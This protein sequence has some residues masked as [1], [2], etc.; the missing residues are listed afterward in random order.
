MKTLIT[1]IRNS[2]ILALMVV[3]VVC[4][5][6]LVGK[7]HSVSGHAFMNHDGRTI[8]LKKGMDVHDSAQI[9][10]S[11]KALVSVGDFYDRYYHLSSGTSVILN[12][13][14]LALQSGSVWSQAVKTN[15]STTI[16]T[17]NLLAQSFNS[18][19]VVTYSVNDKKSQITVISG[20]VNVASPKQPALRY[21]LVAGQFS[22][23]HPDVD[24]GY[25]RT[26]TR[27]G[28]ES[29][30]RT[31]SLFPGVKARDEG[32]AHIQKNKKQGRAI[33]SVESK[34]L[35]HSTGEII[36]IKTNK[37][38]TRAPASSGEAQ[39]YYKNRTYVNKPL[40]K[41]GAQ[42]RVIGASSLVT[43]PQRQVA[44][45]A[46]TQEPLQVREPSKTSEFLKS[47]QFQESHQHKHTPEVQRLIDDLKSF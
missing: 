40:S 43:A 34:E 35:G 27:L 1:N 31:L 3:P 30:N 11:D 6:K 10:V 36:Y 44:S 5:A 20:D 21:A 33:A 23:A 17:A 12:E 42:V 28:F 15:S 25:P 13:R 19:F 8:T 32:I 22:S 41:L 9:I 18:E 46:K 26:P 47:Y 14:S 29:L 37:N 39:K 24:E 38:P 45:V 4:H 2:L 7:V 16:A